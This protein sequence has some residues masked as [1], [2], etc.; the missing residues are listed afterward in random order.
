MAINIDWGTRVINIPKAD[1]TVIQLVPTEIRQ[2]DIN[3]FR[4]IL[5]DLEDNVDGISFPS[6]HLHNTT[7]TVGGVSLARVVEIINGYTV[8]FEDGQYAVNLVGAN[9]NVADVTIVNQ[10]SIRSANSAGL[11]EV[12]TN[13]QDNL[14]PEDIIAIANN[15]WSH[16]EA[17]ALQSDVATI[18]SDVSQILSLTNTQSNMILEIYRLYGLDPTRPLV[19]TET[20]RSAGAE[21]QQSITGNTVQTTVTRT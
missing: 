13:G 1:L 14:K 18:K 5:K 9:S 4:L 21:I 15:V 3:D 12:T 8:R 11:I 16:P 2:L 17:D 6:T 19:V 7:V 10:V 20:S